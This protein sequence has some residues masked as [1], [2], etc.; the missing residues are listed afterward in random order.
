MKKALHL[1][2]LLLV[3]SLA[4]GCFGFFKKTY[5][6]K[7]SWNEEHGDV[8]L[9]AGLDKVK[10]GTVVKLEA[11]PNEG[12][13]FVEWKGEGLTDAQKK[14]NPLQIAVKQNLEL[15]AIFAEIT[16]T[17]TLNVEYDAEQGSI[18]GMPADPT[19]VIP[20][21]QV[22]LKAVP[23]EGYRFGQWGGDDAPEN[24]INQDR[25]QITVDKDINITLTFV[26]APNPDLVVH[27]T[28]FESGAD[29]WAPRGAPTVERVTEQARTGDYSIKVT[30]SSEQG[31][32]NGGALVNLFDQVEAGEKYVFSG[33]VYH[34]E[35]EPKR[36]VM[37]LHYND[38][39]EQ[40]KWVHDIEEMPGGVW[41]KFEAE[42][43]VPEN[44]VGSVFEL[45]F[46]P[47]NDKNELVF[48]IDDVLVLKA[49]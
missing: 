39:G 32:W 26:E 7:V 17:Y 23:K 6:V 15:E 45:F 33:W 8:E 38:G 10:D 28:S 14:Q 4:T 36:M 3:V 20:G 40:Y 35:S 18:E 21:T 27:D 41:T 37:Q 1:L 46:E 9:P 22:T 16:V 11:K 13:Y 48:Y 49:E 5:S 30:P 44:L 2:V 34:A 31:A 12:F 42:Y 47:P 19:K 25:V 43:I 24:Q 29:G